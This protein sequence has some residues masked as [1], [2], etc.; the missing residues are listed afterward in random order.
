MPDILVPL[1][2]LKISLVMYGVECSDVCRKVHFFYPV[3]GKALVG[4][5]IKTVQVNS[6][7]D[8]QFRCYREHQCLSYNLGPYQVDGQ[9]CELSNSDHI[10]HPDDLVPMPGYI[11]RG[12]ENRCSSSQCK[13][14]ASCLSL[15]PTTFQCLCPAGFTGMNC[16]TDIDECQTNQYN[17]P[18][19][20]ICVNT[21]GSY[22]CTCVS[23]LY[24]SA[25]I[26]KII[27]SC[28]DIKTTLPH[29]QDGLYQLQPDGGLNMFWVYCD[30]T[31]FD[32]GWTMCYSTDYLVNLRTEL[33]YDENLPYG[34]NGYRTDCNNIE[35]REILFVDETT[36]DQ[37]FFT[38]KLSS[39][40]VA[41]R[42][43]GTPLPGLW[44]GG[45]IADTSY[46]YQLLICD[47]PFFSGFMISGYTN[48]Y[49][50]CDYWCADYSSPY[51]RSASTSAGFAGV[52]FN[53]NGARALSSR[54]ISVGLR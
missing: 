7:D 15:T 47:H 4:H 42:N 5:V 45:G 3:D 20:E 22:N 6:D 39:T 2:L 23:G 18:L 11:Y 50:R 21:L 35:F 14:N 37:A 32:G 38:Y 25:G 41:A 27:R 43:Y 49:K 30:M 29:A 13:N 44:I 17:C 24:D 12:T 36:G 46:E 19:N 10:R 52:A 40:L 31:S 26:C 28:Q 9:T 8:C 16:E 34:T 54:L 1:I 48:C 33:T 51:F 53:F